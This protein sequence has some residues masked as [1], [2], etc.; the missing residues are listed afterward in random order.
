MSPTAAPPGTGGSVTPPPHWW[1][2]AWDRLS[3][4]LP[5]LLMGGLALLSYWLVR[6]APVPEAVVAARPLS[7]EPDYFMRDFAL[8]TFDAA[9]QLRQELRGTEVRHYPDTGALEVDD[10]RVRSLGERGGLTTAQARRL[11][12]DADQRVYALQGQVQVVRE[13]HTRADG[14]A[15]PRLEFRGES[16]TVDTGTD[17]L[18]SDTPVEM[19]RGGDRLLADRLDYDDRNQVAD[20][21]GR[22]RVTLNPR[23]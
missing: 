15:Q 20:L 12:T 4:Y 8:R 14:Q 16:L 22:V 17:R 13:A 2:R 7:H 23:P 6:L 19:W 5:V 3:I 9:G 21:Q 18:T 1:S 10:A 11:N